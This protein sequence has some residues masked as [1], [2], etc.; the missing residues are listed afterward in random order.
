MIVYRFLLLLIVFV[1][2]RYFWDEGEIWNFYI[3]YNETIRVYG[4]LTELGEVIVIFFIFGF[5]LGYYKWF[6]I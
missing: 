2:Y 6:I 4:V 5:Y 1:V 3:F